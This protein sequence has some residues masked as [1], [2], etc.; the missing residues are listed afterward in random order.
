M[1]FARYSAAVIEGGWSAVLCAHGLHCTGR[2]KSAP[3][4]QRPAAVSVELFTH[5][6]ESIAREMGATLQRTAVS[7]NV[8][9]RL[10]F[11]CGILD[12]TGELVVNAP[13]I[14]VHLGSLGLCVRTLSAQIAWH[15]GDTIITNHPRFGGSH[16]PDVTLVSPAFT[17]DETLLGFVVSRAHHAEI[18]GR[19]PG[20]MPTDATRLSEEGVV[21]PPMHLIQRGAA[22]WERIARLLRAAPHPSRAPED[23]LADLR[24]ALAAN[25]RGVLALEVLAREHGPATIREHMSA[26][27]QCAERGIRRALAGRPDG[28]WSTEEVLDDGTRLCVAVRIT[29]D[30]IAFDFSGSADVHPGNLNATPA[31]VHSCVLYALRLLIDEPL[32]LNEGLM[33]AAT[34]HIPPGMLNPPFPADPKLCPAIVGGNVETSQR[35]VNAII[36]ALGLAAASQGTMNNLTFGTDAFSYYETICGGC[37]AGAGFHGAS[38]VHSHMT[39]TS[40][41]DVEVIEHRYPV[42]IERFAIRPGSGGRGRFEGGDGVTRTLAFLAPMSVSLLTQHRRMGPAGL[43]GGSPGLPGRQSIVRADGTC[44]TLRAIDTGQVAAGDRLVIE[45]PGGGGFGKPRE[46]PCDSDG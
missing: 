24:A 18:G 46:V 27:N 37:G 22:H 19:Q 36:G 44:E 13:H 40:I 26:L 39:N 42:R 17:D 10:D 45:T 30:Q 31:V 4:L 35:L 23:N 16:L 7:T 21:I 3:T 41:T 20:S 8:K 9:E 25:R 14:P 15:P 5:R 34:I 11:S 1:I 29:G 33:R 32:P 28:D 12:A 43:A 6:F 38:A 2:P